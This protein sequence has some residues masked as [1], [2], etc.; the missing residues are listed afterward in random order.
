MIKL[1]IDNIEITVPQGSTL[2]KAAAAIGIQIPVMCHNEKIPNHASCMVCA[3]KNKQK[4][5]FIPSCEVKATEGMDIDCN[6]E[7]VTAFR[8]DALELLLSD[9][10]GDCEAPCRISCPSFMDIPR[11]NRLIA[12]GNFKKALEIVKEEIA[13]PLI[14]GYICSAPCE[15]AC[16]R[17]Q[18]EG[19]VSICQLKKFTALEDSKSGSYYLPEKLPETNK[20]VA[21]IGAGIA[22]L[23]ATFH[24]LKMGYSC[25]VFEKNAKAGGSLLNLAE[26][27][28]PAEILHIE[29]AI[30]RQFGA[31][32]IFNT[33]VNALD[34]KKDFDAV[35]I[36]S[37]ENTK[38]AALDF[39]GDGFST[40]H[41]GIFACGSV[42]KTVKMAVKLVAQGKQA[43]AEVD[44]FLSGKSQQY[45]V[46][47]NSK[48][49]KL[50]EEEIATYLMESTA[51]DRI[52]PSQGRLD[53][54]TAIEAMA[55]AQR[56]LR[57]DCRKASTCK[58]R[59]RSDQYGAQQSKYK[60]AERKTIRKYF[61]QD[62]LVYEPEKC[63][64]CGLCIKILETHN[65]LT[66]FAY[67]GRGF[68]MHIAVPFDK[69]LQLA[70]AGA[71]AECIAACP[72]AALAD[73]NPEENH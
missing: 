36:A 56:C 72:T 31:E 25:S 69:S 42:V 30:L 29:T 66:G 24:L 47:F 61:Q 44:A 13:L 32:F 62:I 27:V 15:N 57:C 26:E 2:L 45:A 16:R 39:S 41:E 52:D 65:D 73:F 60:I 54:F 34:I 38:D 8:K 4:G 10:V 35:L 49:A 14:L 68:D 22:G 12:Q 71:A 63:I 33:A 17:K 23:S 1:K 20:K 59:I 70:I 37:G 51:E 7:E 43:A 50:K 21:V 11:M 58:L 67:I 6:T 19:A 46:Q 18:M 28:L 64:K 53:G 48:F 5:E 55:E 40:V 9:H 3:V